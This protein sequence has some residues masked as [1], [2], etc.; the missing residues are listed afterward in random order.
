MDV[1][2][3]SPDAALASSTLSS[4]PSTEES[5][6]ASEKQRA[7]DVDLVSS[8][9]ARPEMQTYTHVDQKESP[10]IALCTYVIRN[11]WYSSLY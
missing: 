4:E 10:G 11:A 7:P 9:N 8:P 1:S 3:L 2:T 5:V 6:T